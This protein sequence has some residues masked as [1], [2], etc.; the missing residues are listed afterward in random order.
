MDILGVGFW[1]VIVIAI[2]AII[3]IGPRDMPKTAR[4]VGLQLRSIRN[5]SQKMYAEWQHGLGDSIQLDQ[6]H[7][8]KT[9]IDSTKDMLQN[10]P[11]TIKGEID[12]ATK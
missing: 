3:F 12:T 5:I 2:I 1:E 9:E 8:L 6:L 11:K 4:K 7:E 10:L